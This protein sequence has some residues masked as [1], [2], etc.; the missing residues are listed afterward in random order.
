MALVDLAAFETFFQERPDGF[1]V[2]G[3]EREIASAP[4]RISKSLDKLMCP[5]GFGLASRSR[6]R[7]LFVSAKLFRQLAKL[8]GVVPVHPVTES[9]RVFGLSSRKPEDSTFAF[10]DKVVDAEF[11]DGGFRAE[12]QLL[13]DFN[14]DPQPLAVET[15]LESLIMAGHRKEAL[16]CVFVRAA[17]GVMDSHRVI[18]SYGTVEK[19]PT[20][21]ARVL[22]SQLL[23]RLL[24]KPE[25]QNGMFAGDKIAVGDRL[26]HENEEPE[27]AMEQNL[28]K[29]TSRIF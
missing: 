14:L 18:G 19:A 9:L 25:F 7:D 16:I 29:T 22:S 2:L 27:S 23:K 26:K 10:V 6:D 3:T 8:I 24:L 1:V 11:M 5:G 20:L 13:F 28:V 15:I 21:A 17:P 4:L 12:P